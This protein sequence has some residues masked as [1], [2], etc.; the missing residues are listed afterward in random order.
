MTDSDVFR[1]VFLCTGNRA[2]SAMAEALTRQM[3]SG[4]PVEV[5]SAGVLELA[6]GGAL[7]EAVDACSRIGIDLHEHVSRPLSQVPLSDIDLLIGFERSHAA[8]A[9][10]DAD[11]PAERSF[12]LRELLRLTNSAPRD[13][14]ST[15]PDAARRRVAAAHAIRRSDHGFFPDDEIPDPFGRETSVFDDLAVHLYNLC[16]ELADRLFDIKVPPRESAEGVAY[17]G[18]S[19]GRGN[20][21]RRRR[22]R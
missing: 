22:S 20:P 10:V 19:S 8:T 3:T 2:R 6:S 11:A 5:S 13:V 4:Y 1:I 21:F 17:G 16:G 12:L 15:L 18:E 9:V 7:P 14:G